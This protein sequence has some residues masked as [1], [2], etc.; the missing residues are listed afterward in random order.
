MLFLVLFLLGSLNA[1]I[2][3]QCRS[4]KVIPGIYIK[5]GQPA[6]IGF[7][8]TLQTFD[9]VLVYTVAAFNNSNLY[10]ATFYNN[11][12]QIE[13]SFLESK[14]IGDASSGNF[15]LKTNGVHTQD[16][17]V[18]SL[19]YKKGGADLYTEMCSILFVLGKPQKATLSH[20]NNNVLG[21][22]CQLSCASS[23]TTNPT[24]HT[25]NVTFNW[26]VNDI[27]N[28]SNNRYKYG[29]LNKTLTIMSVTKEDANKRFKCSATES[30]D[31]VTG[32]TSD[33]SDE[34]IFTVIC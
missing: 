26:K 11:H 19:Q 13:R 15:T 28:P 27:T 21:K 17:G 18:Y 23:S 20:D 3:W 9:G 32:L 22:D 14:F 8:T 5:S 16:G 33:Y 4:G 29:V 7:Q 31:G 25:L 1:V 12:L 30:G 34:F 10:A 2:G 24:N 6:I